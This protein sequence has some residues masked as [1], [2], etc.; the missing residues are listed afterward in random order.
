M[1][2]YRN[3]VPVMS[4]AVLIAAL[5][6][7]SQA[8]RRTD[9]T[10]PTVAAP[11]RSAAPASAAVPQPTGTNVSLEQKTNLLKLQGDI[12]ALK[13]GMN[14][15][16]IAKYTAAVKA[17]LEAMVAGGVTRPTP[18]SVAKLGEDLVTALT[19]PTTGS[20]G[21]PLSASEKDQLARQINDILVSSGLTYDEVN[22]L[23]GDLK[24]LL[25]ATNISASDV[26]LLV[27]DLQGI[28]NE[29]RKNTGGAAKTAQPP[30]RRGR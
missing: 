24:G 25:L 19:N 29:A 9:P 17:D 6:V 1:S 14:A 30:S 20:S 13:A 26:Q 22:R 3:R 5:G 23:V 11:T 27:S 8:Q 7:P 28:A 21:K 18:G 4:V 2:L 15:S 12:K 16:D 10:G